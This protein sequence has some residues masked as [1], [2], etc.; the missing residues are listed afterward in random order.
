MVENLRPNPG[1]ELPY[2]LTL[3]PAT[4]HHRDLSLLG[5]DEAAAL[6]HQHPTLLRKVDLPP[7]LGP[8]IMCRLEDLSSNT[9]LGMKS[10]F[11]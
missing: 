2:R 8:V 3:H 11:S 9:S 10:Q 6:S 4:V 5:R 7:M 1:R